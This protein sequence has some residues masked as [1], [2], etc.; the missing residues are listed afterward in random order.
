MGTRDPRVD[1][2]IA[3][4]ADFAQPILE[5]IRSTVH[6]ACPDVEETIK[7]SMPFF[8]HNGLL[9]NMA[10]FK[11]HC[12]F[13]FWKGSLIVG[14]DRDREAMG[15]FGRLTKLADLPPKKVFVDL[16]RQ[17]VARNDDGVKT[18]KVR[19]PGL[20]RRAVPTAP[21][22]DLVAALK[23]NAKAKRTFDAFSPSHRKEYI[24]WITEAK[25]DETRQKRLAQTIEWLAEGKAR[26]WKYM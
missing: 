7:W 12:A 23:K 17:A 9:G 19:K 14:S 21:P 2:Y 6:E 16:I 20:P 18:P 4:S 10:A 1:A 3:K 5:H 25:R 13:G 22:A 11:Q 24:Q 15:Q 26:N 8:T